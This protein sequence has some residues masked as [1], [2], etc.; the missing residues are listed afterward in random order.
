M[1]ISSS[2]LTS[3]VQMPVVSTPPDAVTDVA[4]SSSKAP[5]KIEVTISM[6]GLSRLKSEKSEGDKYAD[7]DQAPLP[8]SIKEALK[9]IRQLQEKIEQKLKEL[10]ELTA[11]KTLSEDDLKRRRDALT[12]ELRSMQSA[13]SQA[14]NA[15]NNAMSSRNM[16]LKSRDLAKGLVGMK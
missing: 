11:D 9:N 4:A 13:M 16:D 15:L 8:D 1:K 10:T 7:I 14:T 5:A 6:E 3:P 2:D 12:T